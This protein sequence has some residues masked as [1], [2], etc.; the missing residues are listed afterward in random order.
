MREDIGELDSIVMKE[1]AN[2]LHPINP[3]AVYRAT[4][5]RTGWSIDFVCPYEIKGRV[6]IEREAWVKYNSRIRR[7]IG[8]NATRIRKIFSVMRREE[9]VEIEISE[10]CI[11]GKWRDLNLTWTHTLEEVTYESNDY[12]LPERIKYN[13]KFDLSKEIRNIR[14]AIKAVK[15]LNKRW[16]NI[17]LYFKQ[18]TLRIFACDIFYRLQEGRLL[19]NIEIEPVIV[20][21]L[22][23]LDYQ[24]EIIEKYSFKEFEN[25]VKYAKEHL[26]FAFGS[27]NILRVT[28]KMRKNVRVITYL[29]PRDTN[30]KEREELKRVIN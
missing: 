27:E 11:I 16:E 19:S 9:N 5:D 14:D 6:K 29:L 3:G 17:V 28:F 21:E 18:G 20:I 24:G 15:K 26:I 2:F 12:L 7:K 22:P 30:K 13:M 23:E 25:M 4:I 1:I 8:F 10:N